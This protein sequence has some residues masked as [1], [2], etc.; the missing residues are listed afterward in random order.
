M[1]TSIKFYVN[2]YYILWSHGSIIYI[3]INN[4]RSINHEYFK[5]NFF[6]FSPFPKGLYIVSQHSSDFQV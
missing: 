2:L 5:V 3:K 4:K 1:T 6:R